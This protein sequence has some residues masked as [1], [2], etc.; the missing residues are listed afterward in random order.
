[1]NPTLLFSSVV[2]TLGLL[3]LPGCISTYA[4]PEAYSGPTAVIHSSSE[5][6][7]SVKGKGYY[8][9]EIDGKTVSKSSPMATPYGAGMAVILKDTETKVPAQPVTLT[10]VGATVYAADGAAMIDGMSGGSRFV[11]GEMAFTPKANGRYRVKGTL[12]PKGGES[13]WL[14]DEMSGKMIGQKIVKP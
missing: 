4:L 10:L 5:T 8:V 1:M 14:E 7:S 6:V 13:V 12:E 9:S 11:S 3:A 2:S